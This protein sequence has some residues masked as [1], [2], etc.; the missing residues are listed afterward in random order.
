MT[1][2]WLH[3]F[4]KKDPYFALIIRTFRVPFSFFF[5][6]LPIH[7]Y[8]TIHKFLDEISNLRREDSLGLEYVA[9][10]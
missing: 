3:F 5:Q 8:D 10:S 9:V 7:T 6:Q 4:P 1:L 2:L